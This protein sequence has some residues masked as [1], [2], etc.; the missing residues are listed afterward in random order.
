MQDGII[1]GNGN[2]RYLKTVAAALS[3][4]PTYQ[5][6]MTALIAGTFPIDLNGINEAGWSQL[7]TALNKATFLKDATAALYGLTED[8]VP[9]EV[10]SAVPLG[11]N[12]GWKLLWSRTT[13]GTQQWQAP[14]L[15]GGKSYKIG[16]LVIGGGGSGG[17]NIYNVMEI[18]SGGASGFSLCFT[19]QVTPLNNYNVVVGS[20]GEATTQSGYGQSNGANGGTSA[21]NGKSALGG[22]GGSAADGSGLVSSSMG[23][24]MSAPTGGSSSE[25]DPAPFGGVIYEGN[26][27]V[28]ASS[29]QCFNPFESKAILGA[30]GGARAHPSDPPTTLP[31]GKD[32]LSGLGG[33]D[34]AAS[35]ESSTTAENATAPGCGGGG[36]AIYTASGTGI[37]ATSGA[38]ADGAVYIYV[39]GDVA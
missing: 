21:F 17:A 1:A 32:P 10:L 2:S 36:V 19:M 6:F 15:F 35:R 22:Q 31:A 24:Q 8:A 37:V 30:G 11:I 3:L 25:D 26:S 23:G 13:A 7:G 34:G 4:Y 27:S 18:A 33:G 28:P 38:G 5:D 39:Q 16:V 9:D 20:G 12:I 29:I 14:D